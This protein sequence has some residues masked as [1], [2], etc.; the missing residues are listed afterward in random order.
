MQK[1]GKKLLAWM[2]AASMVFSFSMPTQAAKKKPALSKKKAVITV[3]KILTLKVKNISKKTKVTWK[4]KNKKI[5]TVSKKGK[6]KAKKAGTTKITA[7]FRYQGKKYV[8]TCKVT[9]KKKKTVVVTNAPTKVPTKAPTQKPAVTPTATPTQKPGT[10]TV[11]PTQKPV[12]TPTATPTQKPGVPTATPTQKPVTPTVTP[13]TEPAEPTAT[14]TN[15]PAGPTVTP[16]ADPDEPTAT[17]TAEPTRVPGTP[18]PVTDPTK[19]LL[20]DFEDGTNQYVTGRQGEEELTVV[21]GGYNDNYCLKVSNRVK[22]WAGPTIDIT[23]NVTDF[24]TYKIEAYVKQTTGSNKTINCMWESMDYAGAMAYTTVQNVVAPNGTWTKVD[25]TVVAP[26]DVSKLSLYFEMANY[27]N[28][29]Y[30]DNI[31]ITEKHLDM[32]AVLAAPSLKEAYANRFPMGCA[33]YSY[34]LQNPEILSFIKHHYSTVTFA[35]ELKPENLLNEE[36][37]KASEDGMPVINTDVIDKCL[38]LAQEN[39]LSVRFHTLVWY[40]QTP[41]WYFCKNYTPEYDGTGTAKKNITN[42]VDKE[43]MLARIESYVKQVITYAETN[44]PGVVYAYDVVNEVIDSNGCKLRTVSSSLYGAI[45]TDDDN[46][47]ITKSFEYARE[48]EK[49]ANSSAKLFY[50]DFVGLASPGQMKAVVKYLADAKD[51]GNIDGLGMQAHQTN[52][53]VTDGDNIKNALKLFQQNGYEVQIT[54]LDFASKD[55]SEA[56]NETLAAAYQKFMNI[57]LQRMD[58]TTA[59]VNVSNVTFW[60]LTDLDTWLNSFYSDGSTYYPSLFD[61]NYLPKKAFTA[62]INLV[63]GVVEPT[64]TP[65]VAPT[66][67]PTVTPTATPTATPTVDPD[68][69]PTPTPVITPT[70][71]PTAEP[72]PA[73]T[74]ELDLAEGNIVISATGYTIGNAEETAFNGNY[75]ISS[76][77]Q[78]ATAYYILVT[79]GT[80]TITLNDLVCTSSESSPIKLSG[81]AKVNLILV[82]TSA[83]TGSGYHAGIEV[84]SG[85]ELTI[86]GDGQLTALGGNESAGIGAT[87][88]GKTSST[89][90]RIIIRSGTI[91]ACNTGRNAAG[92]GESRYAKG[93]GEIYIYGGNIYATSSGNGAGVGGGGTADASAKTM[94]IGIYGGIISAGGSTYAIGDGK[95]QSICEVTVTGGACYST[96]SGKTMFGSTWET[97]DTY[98]GTEIDTTKL[99]GIQSVTIDGVDQGISSFFITAQAGTV[100]KRLKLNLYVEKGASHTIVVT[101][102]NGEAHEYTVDA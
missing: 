35:D 15:E 82:G 81:D 65:T 20:L 38:S 59:P 77:A 21:E 19:A 62:L 93:G 52:L 24:T 4:S 36:A 46:T 99:S 102:T 47:Y 76:T 70:P 88:D 43:T 41:D 50:N 22:N 101:D 85:C 25:A 83:L 61:E 23:H 14:A 96:N 1:N 34:N 27:S 37:T 53:G 45:F 84:P 73:E 97:Q 18:I 74:K 86:S 39:D 89:L 40:S 28:D 92:I 56:G 75:T 67:T 95:S 17:P 9:V 2:L 80:H 8:K 42:L 5:A 7:R 71:E 54:E 44:Y 100:N 58:D 79:G 63:N 94:K 60:N 72:E 57:I 49:A 87:S 3:G 68:A 11:T 32:D 6:V 13:T 69:T 29:F 66:A 16:T 12:V 98:V 91:I 55:N 90:G 33:V 10:P 26:G 31:S 51:A 30:V 64:A 48:A 78:S